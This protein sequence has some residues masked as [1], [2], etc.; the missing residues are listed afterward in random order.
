[1]KKISRKNIASLL[2]T[3]LVVAAT[4]VAPNAL[5]AHISMNPGKVS[6]TLEPGG[7]ASIPVSTT[8]TQAS[9]GDYAYFSLVPVGD[10]SA[11]FGR[12][13]TV[14][15]SGPYASRTSSLAVTVP[16]GTGGGSYT[17][18]FNAQ[19]MRGR[20]ITADQLIVT[21]E[22]PATNLCSAPPIFSPITA[23]QNIIKGKNN[24]PVTIELSGT[25]DVG[26]GCE[27]AGTSYTL[28]DEYG[29]LGGTKDL[30][31]ASD[32]SFSASVELMASRKGNDKDGRLYS[33]SFSAEN[34]AG[35]GNGDVIEIVVSHDNR[36]Q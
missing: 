35:V 20:S 33:I 26:D 15:L 22:V 19:V 36:K 10:A 18:T 7:S 25:V 12:A 32:G 28:T 5:A 30:N 34:E 29:E 31:I 4:L 14:N 17:A 16:E 3:L 2:T 8:L 1:M 27:L 6:I 23:S 24:K 11:W 9:R 13:P 21:L